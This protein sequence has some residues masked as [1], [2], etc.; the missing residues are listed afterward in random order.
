MFKLSPVPHLV[1]VMTGFRL[2]GV[3]TILQEVGQEAVSVLE[4]KEWRY[5]EEELLG[6]FEFRLCDAEM[7]EAE[8][9]CWRNFIFWLKSVTSKFN[10]QRSVHNISL[11]A[12]LF[13]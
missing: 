2:G 9:K 12:Y 3:L 10:I 11:Q 4:I 7:Q 13:P 6:L 1:I 5:T 8:E